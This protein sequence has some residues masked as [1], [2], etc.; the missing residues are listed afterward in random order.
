MTADKRHINRHSIFIFDCNDPDAVANQSTG[1]L[2]LTAIEFGFE[3]AHHLAK[4]LYIYV[5]FFLLL[6]LWE[7]DGIRRFFWRHF[8]CGDPVGAS[9]HN[10]F[11][12][13]RDWWQKKKPSMKFEWEKLNKNERE[14]KAQRHIRVAFYGRATAGDVSVS[15]YFLLAPINLSPPPPLPPSLFLLLL[16]LLLWFAS[17][18]FLWS[19]EWKRRWFLQHEN[20][21]RFD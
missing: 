15:F 3:M 5:Y 17:R 10:R 16:L 12:I 1:W 6:L 9:Q 4:I 21:N 20:K 13:K 2:Q 7:H 19:P 8:L 14:T 11:R 18:F